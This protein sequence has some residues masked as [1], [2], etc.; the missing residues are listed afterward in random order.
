VGFLFLEHTNFKAER[1][2]RKQCPTTNTP[3]F[4][5]QPIGL[6]RI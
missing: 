5:F 3:K 4:W 2:R 6:L 1:K